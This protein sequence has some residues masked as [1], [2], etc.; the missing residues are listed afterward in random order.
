V[1]LLSD[2]N[3][4]CSVGAPQK[5]ARQFPCDKGSRPGRAGRMRRSTCLHALVSHR[6]IADD[7]PATDPLNASC[8]TTFPSPPSSS[9]ASRFLHETPPAGG[10]I[11]RPAAQTPR[12]RCLESPPRI[13]PALFESAARGRDLIGGRASPDDG[14][15]HHRLRRL[16]GET[17]HGVIQEP[18]IRSVSA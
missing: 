8:E 11:P 14:H 12:R 2:G 15:G 4:A 1:T 3:L 5:R 9:Y 18:R 7:E 16:S 13:W 10:P 17:L 6:A